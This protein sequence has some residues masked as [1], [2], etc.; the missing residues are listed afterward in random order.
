VSRIV[1]IDGHIVPPERAV[2]SVFDRGF[3]YGDGIFESIRVYG[4]RPFAREEHLARLVRSAASLRIPL[5]VPID[6]LGRELD[7]A[8]R[9]SG[10]DDAYVRVMLTRGVAPRPALV[11][12][13]PLT[14]TRVL[15]VEPLRTPPR[16]MYAHGVSAVT[17]KWGRFTAPG[18]AAKS[19]PYVTNYLA[20]EEARS[21]GADEAI[22][23]GPDGLV[24]EA[25]TANVFVIDEDGALVTPTD[26]PH[27]LGGITRGQILDLAVT[28]GFSCSMRP[29]PHASLTSAR[30]VFLTS[31]IREVLSVVKVDGAP[32]GNGKPGDLTRTLHAALR[33]RAGAKGPNPWE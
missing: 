25:T 13:A 16:E 26:G 33:F 17:L 15:L 32:V 1:S 14:A 24:R 4:G 11:P 23:V 8:V 31:S 2:V 27:V 9:A 3:L 6:A 22:F 28:L 5:P 19:L 10:Q 18:T 7:E 29:V 21:R 20:L 30:E 12:E